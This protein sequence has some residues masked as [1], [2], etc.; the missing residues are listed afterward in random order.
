MSKWFSEVGILTHAHGFRR[1]AD[2]A[3]QMRQALGAIAS[4]GVIPVIIV[5]H[6]SQGQAMVDS[7]MELDMPGNFVF[8]LPEG[9]FMREL[10]PAQS[11]AL[12]GSLTLQL[13]YSGGSATPGH[14]LS[15][16]LVTDGWTEERLREAF[17]FELA[18]PDP[19]LPE[20]Q[21][22]SMGLYEQ[23][24]YDSVWAFAVAAAFVLR[25]RGSGVTMEEFRSALYSAWTKEGVE[26]EGMSGKVKFDES[27][28]RDLQTISA[29]ILNIGPLQGTDGKPIEKVVGSW[30]GDTGFAFG[31][32]AGFSDI[33]WGFDRGTNVPM[34]PSDSSKLS[35]AAIALITLGCLAAIGFLLLVRQFKVN[36]AMIPPCTLFLR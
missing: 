28:D 27:G 25:Q 15:E 24:A 3:T 17:D 11:K 9:S 14:S 22:R 6:T 10:T 16:V 8:L 7:L 31:V 13:E 20:L 26:F 1:G 30:L 23:F 35:P 21:S 2:E 34:L 36:C 4:T 12:E 33:D 32:K 19:I 5:I 18:S 29:S